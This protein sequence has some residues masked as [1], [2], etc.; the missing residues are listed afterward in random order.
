MTRGADTAP[1]GACHSGLSYGA[2]TLTAADLPRPVTRRADL[3]AI[4]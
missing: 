2:C 3:S 1:A 4:V